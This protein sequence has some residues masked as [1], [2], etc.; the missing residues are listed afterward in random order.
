MNINILIVDDSTVT[1][2]VL[3]RCLDSLNLDLGDK[4]Q[5][6]NGKQAMELLKKEHIDVVFTDLN[7]P[8]MDGVELIRT[9]HHSG[10]FAS[11]PVIV[12]TTEENTARVQQLDN[13]PIKAKIQKPFWP[14]QIKGILEDIFNS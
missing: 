6:S 5:A 12:I 3:I 11:L 13:Y 2:S 10:K 4:F 14:E 1:R 8:E 7:M 9:M